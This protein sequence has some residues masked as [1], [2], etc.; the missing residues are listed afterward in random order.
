[1]AIRLDGNTPRRMITNLNLLMRL[2]LL[3]PMF[4]LLLSN[5]PLKVEL[6]VTE[7]TDSSCGMEGASELQCCL[8]PV[9]K[10][11]KLCCQN[12]E[13]TCVYFSCFQVMAPII[14]VTAFV[15][16][17]PANEIHYSIYRHPLW[18]NPFL[19]APVEPPDFV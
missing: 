1:M 19:K 3:L 13:S 7:V 15:F 17:P 10:K 5:I 11:R 8:K 4:A 2:L 12:K 6:S 18:S 16:S 14:S 9:Q